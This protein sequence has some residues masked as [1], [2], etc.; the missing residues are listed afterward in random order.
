MTSKSLEENTFLKITPQHSET[1]DKIKNLAKEVLYNSFAQAIIKV[2]LTPHLSL[3]IF[4][5]ML[6]V[7]SSV[8]T[9]YMMIQSIL[10]YLSYDV[11]TK[12]R[13]I[14]ETSSLF[15]KITFCNVNLHTTKYAFD[16]FEKFNENAADNAAQFVYEIL[17]LPDE[18]KTKFGHSLDD[19][20]LSCRFNSKSCNSR[21]FTR[22]FDNTY[23]NCYSFNSGFD[24]NGTKVDLK[25]SAF[26]GSLFGLQLT[27]YA[28]VYEGFLEEISRQGF[29]EI[30]GGL[31]IIIRIENSSWLNDFEQDGIFL[32]T[33]LQTDIV[34][35]REFKQ[36][37]PKPYSLCEIDN[38]NLQE[39]TSNS[40][41]L[42]LIANSKYLYTNNLCHYQCYQKHLIDSVGVPSCFFVSLF[43]ENQMNCTDNDTLDLLFGIHYNDLE[44]N[45]S[46]LCPL[47]CNQILFKTSLSSCNLL[48]DYY[49]S[50]I[51]S[52]PNLDGD[53]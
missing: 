6:T 22:S 21:D 16:L 25:E 47:E 5:F 38:L 26:V 11:I 3:K 48:G 28:N 1:S 46:L 7:F 12:I 30:R 32:Q 2:F 29:D 34:I 8:L 37:L 15:P 10:D 49:I 36:V 31:G 39:V 35:N 17:K 43:P 18:E 45:C 20:L 23:G 44:K 40:P 50:L 14:Q 24:E 42:N 51:E 9:S 13:S 19:I 41:L 53:F 52:N 27:L 4:W 33:G